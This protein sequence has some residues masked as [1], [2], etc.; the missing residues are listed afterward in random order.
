MTA[1]KSRMKVS[2]LTETSNVA[3][4]TAY[5]IISAMF[6]ENSKEWFPR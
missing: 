1:K 3:A 4:S 5:V 2:L 6:P